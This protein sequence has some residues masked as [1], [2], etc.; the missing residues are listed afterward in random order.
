MMDREFGTSFIFGRR[1]RELPG[2]ARVCSSAATVKYLASANDYGKLRQKTNTTTGNSAPRPPIHRPAPLVAP[3]AV[4]APAIVVAAPRAAPVRRSAPPGRGQSAPVRR[5]APP[6]RGRRAAAEVDKSAGVAG[7]AAAGSV[8]K[9]ARDAVVPAVTGAPRRR[10]RAR[11]RGFVARRPAAAR[12][13][14]GG[15]GRPRRRGRIQRLKNGGRRDRRERGELAR[16][17]D[18]AHRGDALPRHERRNHSC[19]RAGGGAARGALLGGVG[20]ARVRAPHREARPFQ[21][22]AVELPRGRGVFSLLILDEGDITILSQA[23]VAYGTDAAEDG[24]QLLDPDTDGRLPTQ[25]V[26]L[27]SPWPAAMATGAGPPASAAGV[28]R[29]SLPIIPTRKPVLLPTSVKSAARKRLTHINAAASGSSVSFWTT[30]GSRSAG[31]SAPASTDTRIA[32]CTVHGSR[33]RW[34]GKGVMRAPHW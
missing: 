23:Q 22:R 21:T 11:S 15:R 26:L 9:A 19:R 16:A 24:A 30:L 3:E 29:R 13:P 2:A 34:P 4:P 31:P 17:G 25:S 20:P 32:S 18:T 7:A 5:R 10:A 1:R 14:S 33:P 8:V 28:S 12:A 27:K 6:A